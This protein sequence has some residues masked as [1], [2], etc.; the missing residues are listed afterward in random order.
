MQVVPHV[1]VVPLPHMQVRELA[2]CAMRAGNTLLGCPAFT[3]SGIDPGA[4]PLRC[5]PS[6]MILVLPRS[7]DRMKAQL[8]RSCPSPPSVLW[9][10]SHRVT[11]RHTSHRS[12]RV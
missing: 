1:L 5:F 11:L 2:A 8:L 6:N 9:H 3:H 7:K 12:V 10:T 4:R